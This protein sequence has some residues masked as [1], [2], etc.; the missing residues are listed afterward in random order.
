MILTLKQLILNIK[1]LLVQFINPSYLT[2]AKEN[3]FVYSVNENGK[4]VLLALSPIGLNLGLGFINK[5]FLRA[6]PCYIINDTKMFIVANYSVILP[7]F[8]KTMTAV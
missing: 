3:N 1:M 8:N 7:F 5:I 6:D 2:V 4:K